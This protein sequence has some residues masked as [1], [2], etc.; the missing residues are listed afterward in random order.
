MNFE[1]NPNFFPTDKPRNI[2]VERI[3]CWKHTQELSKRI[4]QPLFTKLQMEYIFL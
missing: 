1:Y 2:F 3:D 4:E